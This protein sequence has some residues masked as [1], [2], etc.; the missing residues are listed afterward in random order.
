MGKAGDPGFTGHPANSLIRKMS[1]D[2]RSGR[3][4]EV[5]RSYSAAAFLEEKNHCYINYC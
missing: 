5:T 4:G 2:K 1:T 3:F